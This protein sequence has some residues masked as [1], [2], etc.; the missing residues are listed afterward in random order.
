MNRTKCQPI[1]GLK[2]RRREYWS[3]ARTAL[4]Y[5]GVIAIVVAGLCAAAVKFLGTSWVAAAAVSAAVMIGPIW[6]IWPDYP[7]Q[8]D[9]ER[10][11]ALRRAANLPDIVEPD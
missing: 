9:V 6:M 4:P 3:D 2:S 1:A 11:Q 5:V 10:D 7:T 8:A